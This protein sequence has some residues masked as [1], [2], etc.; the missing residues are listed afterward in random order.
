MKY[1]D[2]VK[3][4]VSQSCVRTSIY[5][6]SAAP[7]PCPLQLHLHQLKVSKEEHCCTI[8]A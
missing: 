2:C 7:L 6:P 5:F 1:E 8:A 4:V 3:V